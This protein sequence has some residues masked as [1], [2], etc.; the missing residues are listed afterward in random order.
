LALQVASYVARGRGNGGRATALSLAAMG[1]VMASSYLG[2]YLTLERGVGVDQT[3][4]DRGPSDWT[5]A[6]AA[7]DLPD[8]E[9]RS[10]VVGDTPV[11]LVR[12]AGA[13]HA[14]HDRC[15]HRGCSL[16]EG[17]LDGDVVQCGCH[18]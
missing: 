12:T 2:G 14:L 4:F 10:V 17:E 15:S 13:V 9:L 6:T 1:G 16:A 8:G 11:L 18:G 7:T 5:E 3:A